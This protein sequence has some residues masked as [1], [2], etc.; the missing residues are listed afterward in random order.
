VEQEGAA[1]QLASAEL[2]YKYLSA[3]EF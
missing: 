1:N 3:L 2:D